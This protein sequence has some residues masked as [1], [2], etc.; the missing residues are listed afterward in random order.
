MKYLYYYLA[1]VGGMIIG[2][3]LCILMTV[4]KCNTCEHLENSYLKKHKNIIGIIILLLLLPLSGC[5]QSG[6]E[7]T[8]EYY[9]AKIL[10]WQKRQA[11][12]PLITPKIALGDNF[13]NLI[14]EPT[15]DLMEDILNV[16]SYLPTINYIGEEGDYWKTSEE[17]MR[18]K[19]GDC[20]DLAILSFVTLRDSEILKYYNADIFLRIVHIDGRKEDHV[21]VIISTDSETL[22]IDD[23][24]WISDY[25]QQ[26]DEEILIDFDDVSIR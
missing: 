19:G 18:D 15:G 4:S 7:Y 9:P 14:I 1:A 11:L 21:K 5:G 20:E 13:K 10:D 24:Y 8:P 22:A 12:C 17:T 6:S 3:I 23:L 25:E 26:E 16:L 2:Y